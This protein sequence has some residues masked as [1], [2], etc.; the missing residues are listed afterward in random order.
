MFAS[1]LST[2]S[3]FALRIPKKVS[4]LIF[5]GG[6]R[7]P[8]QA[9]AGR[10]TAWRRGGGGV[11]VGGESCLIYSSS[12]SLGSSIKDICTIV[13]SAL[14][15]VGM[16]QIVD[17][18]ENDTICKTG[19]KLVCHIL[20]LKT[21][22][23]IIHK[24]IRFF[25]NRAPIPSLHLFGTGLCYKIHQPPLLHLLFHDPPPLLECGR[26]LCMVLSPSFLLF[27]VLPSLFLVCLFSRHM[28][29]TWFSTTS[30]ME[31]MPTK[32]DLKIMTIML[33]PPPNSLTYRCMKQRSTF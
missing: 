7:P 28:R 15:A 23:H 6:R 5:P 18:D 4:L 13:L 8:T 25:G 26:H 20:G 31:A 9:E 33:A 1:D 2:A 10:V 27:V 22:L 29:K 17:L 11:G 12:F 32:K 24:D 16:G 21:S 3:K 14:S 30:F 19:F